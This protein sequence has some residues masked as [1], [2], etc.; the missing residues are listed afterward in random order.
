MTLHIQNP[1]KYSVML[2]CSFCLLHELVYEIQ[3]SLLNL[4]YL[5]DLTLSF[6]PKIA[7]QLRNEDFDTAEIPK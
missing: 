7:L 2:A 4:P 1:R 5:S 3:K 6:F